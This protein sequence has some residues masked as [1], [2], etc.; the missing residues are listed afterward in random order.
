[1]FPG[2]VFPGTVAEVIQDTGTAQL[3]PSGNIP[4]LTGDPTAGRYAVRIV[5]DNPDDT[6]MIPQGAGGT[7]AVY[8]NVGKPFHVI[9]K[10]VMRMQAWTAYLTSPI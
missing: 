5:L 9:T 1:M 8:T 10:V 3:T 4:V 2:K 7:V 6:K